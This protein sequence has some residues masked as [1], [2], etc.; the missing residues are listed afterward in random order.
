L[1][2]PRS[3]PIVLPTSQYLQVWLL[4]LSDA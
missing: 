1:V 2:V 3:I 4:Y